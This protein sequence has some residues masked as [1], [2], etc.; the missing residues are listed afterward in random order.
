MIDSWMSLVL[1]PLLLVPAMGL[2]SRI[3]A[4]RG[5]GEEAKRK[6]LHAGAGLASLSLPTLFD[7]AWSVLA[8]LT[9]VLAW[10]FGVRASARLR[11]IFGG[12]LHDLER[13]SCGEFCFA[14]ALACLLIVAQ[15]NTVHYALPVLILSLADA[16]AA[17]VGRAA[18]LVPLRGPAKGKTLSG[19]ATFFAVSF[20]TAALVLIHFAGMPAGPGAA[21]AVMVAAGTTCAEAVSHRGLDN[22]TVPLVAWATLVAMGV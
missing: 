14:A 18:P 5:I 1:P 6:L 4:R 22:V 8:A 2:I 9:I 20:L 13:N 11:R 17:L 15:D 19:C 16:S 12:V 21:I 10:M 3:E 7:S